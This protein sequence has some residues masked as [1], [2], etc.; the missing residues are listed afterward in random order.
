LQAESVD[1][2]LQKAA[3]A[4]FLTPTALH[5]AGFTLGNIAREAHE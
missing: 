2:D 5:R 1:R 4:A 3:F